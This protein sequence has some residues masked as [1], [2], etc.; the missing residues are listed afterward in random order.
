M[1]DGNTQ[2]IEARFTQASRGFR[3]YEERTTRTIPVVALHRR[4]G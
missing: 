2:I 1:S 4:A 3:A